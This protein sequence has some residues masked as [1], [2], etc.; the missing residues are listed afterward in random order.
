MF[1]LCVMNEK[2]VFDNCLLHVWF[3]VCVTLF[4]L[5]I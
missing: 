1:D 4:I 5:L 2:A 3:F